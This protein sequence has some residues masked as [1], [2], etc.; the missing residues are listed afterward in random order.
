MSDMFIG[1]NFGSFLNVEFKE[2][3]CNPGQATGM[4]STIGNHS[5]WGSWYPNLGGVTGKVDLPSDKDAAQI[6]I[7]QVT[8]VNQYYDGYAYFDIPWKY[9]VDA[10]IGNITTVRMEFR[11]YTGGNHGVTKYS[12]SWHDVNHTDDT[13]TTGW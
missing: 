10:V 8:Q 5:A 3:S 7:Q 6:F 9:K 2:D 4:L 1:P 11:C 12:E 13:A